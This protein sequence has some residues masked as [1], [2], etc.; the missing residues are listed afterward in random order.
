MKLVQR[1]HSF[2]Q[3]SHFASE[4]E[5]SHSM[6]VNEFVHRAIV[7]HGVQAIV[8]SWMVWMVARVDVA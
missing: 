7:Q 2:C 5:E 1:D 8:Y 4:M 6:V 3:P